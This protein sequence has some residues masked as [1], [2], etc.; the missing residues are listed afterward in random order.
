MTP[1]ITPEGL[2]TLV[3]Q[4]VMEIYERESPLQQQKSDGSPL[5]KADLAAGLKAPWP[6][7]PMRS[8]ESL[9]QFG[10]REQP[11]L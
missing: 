1:T 9:N 2:Q 4:D 6:Q 10:P 7:I 3:Q 11:P 5:T 8:E